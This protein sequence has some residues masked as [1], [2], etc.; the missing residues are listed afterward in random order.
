MANNEVHVG[1]VGTVV[2][3]E[4][5]GCV[6]GSLQVLDVSTATVKQIIFSSPTGVA[7]AKTATFA[8]DGKDGKIRYTLAEGDLNAP[9]QWTLQGYI[10]MP[11]WQGHTS[12]VRLPV[13]ANLD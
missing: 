3:L 11:A 1:D 4:I 10:E 2:T 5:Q 12:V 8:T 7:S 9:G 6:N 13:D